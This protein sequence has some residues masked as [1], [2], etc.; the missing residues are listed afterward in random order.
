MTAGALLIAA[1]LV[2]PYDEGIW[3]AAWVLNDAGLGFLLLYLLC[4]YICRLLCLALIAKAR[5]QQQTC[6]ATPLRF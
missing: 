4:F 2:T 5:Q 6:G 3:T 1:E